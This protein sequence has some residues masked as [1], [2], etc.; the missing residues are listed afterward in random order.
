MGISRRASR[1]QTTLGGLVGLVGWAGSRISGQASGML[2][3]GVDRDG[4]MGF[5]KGQSWAF[6]LFGQV[7]GFAEDLAGLRVR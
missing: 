2:A 1:R 3:K 4:T 6:V 5:L 7:G